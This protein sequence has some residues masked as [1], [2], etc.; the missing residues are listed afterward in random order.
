[1]AR[2]QKH[3]AAGV[4]ELEL[5]GLTLRTIG[6]I[7]LIFDVTI[8]AMF[9]FVGFRTGSYLWFYWT[10]IQGALGA[11]LVVIGRRRDDEASAVMGH[12]FEPHVHAGEMPPDRHRW[13]A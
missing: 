7:L 12:T 13:A 9:V 8:I 5:R 2:E 1:M 10:V 4:D 3:V 11:G 6:G